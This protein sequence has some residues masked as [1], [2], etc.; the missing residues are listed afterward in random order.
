LLIWQTIAWFCK[1]L[2]NYTGVATAP[3][4]D[5]APV[6]GRHFFRMSFAVSAAEITEAV[7][8]LQPWFA[9]LGDK[10]S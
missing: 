2:L 10:K 8:R 5:L 7:R 4:I 9:A 1:T 6:D 3:G